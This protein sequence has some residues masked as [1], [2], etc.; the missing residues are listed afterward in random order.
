[1]QV[2]NPSSAARRQRRHFRYVTL[3]TALVAVIA[4][5]WAVFVAG[6][7][8]GSIATGTLTALALV[9]ASVATLAILA[10]WRKPLSPSLYASEPPQVQ[11]AHAT[12]HAGHIVA[13]F[14][15]DPQSI[16]RVNLADRCHPPARPAAGLAQTTLR[17]DL[18]L[19]L[20]GLT[21][22]EI[23][24]GETGTNV[25]GDLAAATALG[26]DMV[27]R[28]GMTG[29][30]VS[31]ATGRT[32]RSAFIT[33]VIEDPRTRKELEALLRD[34]KR[35]TMRLM[36]ENRHLIVAVRD[37]LLRRQQLSAEEVYRVLDEAQERRCNDD[38]VLVD[39]RSAGERPR[40][41][42]GIAEK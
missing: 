4:W 30:L 8:S 6:F 16:T 36:L 40:P 32:R 39:L 17:R 12:H 31:L 3:V 9:V 27:G 5:L 42:L 23:F 7:A 19:A 22:E 28:F 29:S 18:R 35:E 2:G 1:M 25:A 37:A 34:T 10:L 20:A 24:T 41:L 15:E 14:A 13:R 11:Y 33:R 26:A 38:Q 21:A